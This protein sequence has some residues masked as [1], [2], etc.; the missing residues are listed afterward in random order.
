MP[1]GYQLSPPG[2]NL[3]YKVVVKKV[4]F[5]A[6]VGTFENTEIAEINKKKEDLQELIR[7]QDGKIDYRLF[8]SACGFC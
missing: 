6:E 4:C 3:S 5:S 2:N 8:S 7:L 1:G